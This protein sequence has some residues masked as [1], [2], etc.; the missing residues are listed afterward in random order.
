MPDD[1][2]V[3]LEFKIFNVIFHFGFIKKLVC[4]SFGFIKYS[5]I[6]Y[7]VFSFIQQDYSNENGP[8]SAGEDN[9]LNRKS[10]AKQRTASLGK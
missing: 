5:N 2:F 6:I 10:Q 9:I 8:L 4:F 7:C 1:N 3:I